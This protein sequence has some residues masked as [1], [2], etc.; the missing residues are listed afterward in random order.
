MAVTLKS[1]L[2][3]W[4]HWRV[5]LGLDHSS[6]NP[7][8]LFPSFQPSCAKH[9]PSAFPSHPGPTAVMPAISKLSAL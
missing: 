9:F 2:H 1:V 8:V 4:G 3:S 6:C 5:W 7:H